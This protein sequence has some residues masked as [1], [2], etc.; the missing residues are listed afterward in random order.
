MLEKTCLD[1]ISA[2]LYIENLGAVI[3]LVT[4]SG[5]VEINQF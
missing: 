5:F 4:S 3:D 2:G 1:L